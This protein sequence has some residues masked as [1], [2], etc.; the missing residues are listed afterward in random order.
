MRVGGNR[1]LSGYTQKKGKTR[2]Q[3]RQEFPRGPTLGLALP[4][5]AARKKERNEEGKEGRKKE[6]NTREFK[7]SS[8]QKPQ[9][10][11]QCS[12][13]EASAA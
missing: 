7:G 1:W 2:K 8:F 12:W 4:L 6:R 5:L 3:V 10:E 13:S 9:A 11:A